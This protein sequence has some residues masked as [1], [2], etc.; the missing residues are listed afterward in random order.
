MLHAKQGFDLKGYLHHRNTDL[1]VD[2]TDLELQR[3]ELH[4]TMGAACARVGVILN[5]ELRRF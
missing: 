5:A 4:H 2:G 3:T 1:P